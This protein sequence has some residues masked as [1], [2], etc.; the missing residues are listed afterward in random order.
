[1]LEKSARKS[2]FWFSAGCKGGG[3]ECKK[4]CLSLS[5]MYYKIIL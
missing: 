1:M 2:V 5:L 3:G 4:I